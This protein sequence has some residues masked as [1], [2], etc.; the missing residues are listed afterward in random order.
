MS[1]RS[2]ALVA[3]LALGAGLLATVTAPAASAATP[4]VTL[5]SDQVELSTFQ[6]VDD[7]HQADTG[8]GGDAFFAFG[9]TV[10]PPKQSGQS[11]TAST[12]VQMATTMETPAQPPLPA[13][14]LNDIALSGTATS[15]ATRTA[16]DTLGVPVS[17]SEGQL[18]VD[19][20]AD[21]PVP[22]FFGG[23]MQ[24]SETDTDECSYAVVDLIGAS[25]ARHFVASSP[26]GCHEAGAVRQKG[27]DEL[28]TL[29][30]GSYELTA[31]YYSEVDDT[32]DEVASMSASSKLTFD[33][34]FM[35]PK[36]AFRTTVN[37]SRATF[38][39]VGSSAGAAGR[40]LTKYKWTFG[41][42]HTA[43]TTTN[44]VTHTYPASPRVAP[45][46]DVKLQVVDSGKAVSA[47]V[48]HKLLGT[49]TGLTVTKT[50]GTAKAA[51]KVTPRRGGHRVV[52]TLARKRNGAFRTIATHRP[53]LTSSSTYATTFARPAPG[54]CRMTAR[55]PGDATHLASTRVKTF[56]C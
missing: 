3:A 1:R 39:A 13:A 21:Q 9:D 17:D 29:P 10:N 24:T 20:T 52:V 26:A 35:P 12:F 4:V 53:V 50:A 48:T 45:T 54:S 37:G 40:P 46:Y 51:G 38:N 32:T 30:A 27:W 49:V 23:F 47:P 22:V 41:D 43:T 14:P 7:D 55:Y 18:S 34:A 5:D 28:V 31:D 33:L 56:T 36:A 16:N 44:T 25:F 8:S 6:Y 2:H 42:G 15:G 19:F 11:G